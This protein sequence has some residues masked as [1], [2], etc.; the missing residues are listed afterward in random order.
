MA[1]IRRFG[2]TCMAMSVGRLALLLAFLL[3]LLL[4][5]AA[6]FVP[7]VQ[8][9]SGPSLNVVD[10]STVNYPT[11][12]VTFEALDSDGVPI[13][14]LDRSDFAVS[15]NGQPR[16]VISGYSMTGSSQALDVMLVLDTSVT[17]KNDG[18]LGQV[19]AAAEAF[20]D[21]M[22][23]VDQVGLIQF[24]TQLT[25][26]SPFSGDKAMLKRKI[27]G[28]T[29]QGNTRIYDALVLALN[30]TAPETGSK[31]V[32]LMTDGQDTES[33]AS[34]DQVLG[35]IHYTGIRVYTIG[36]GSDVDQGVLRE[37][38][39]ASGGHFY[40]APTAADIGNAF[41]LMSSQLR[42]RYQVIYSSPATAAKGSTMTLSLTAKTPQGLATG[43]TS[44]VVPAVA[45]MNQPSQPAPAGSSQMSQPQVA[46]KATAA[47]GKNSDYAAGGL[48]ALG[49]LLAAGGLAFKQAQKAHHTRL[50]YFI[51]GARGG[52]AAVAVDSGEGGGSAITGALLLPVVPLARLL[53]RMIARMLPPTQVRRTSHQ[54]L[55]AGNPFGWRVSHYV[56]ARILCGLGLAV[57]TSLFALRLGSPLLGV[58]IIVAFGF[59]GYRMP[60]MLLKRRIKSRQTSILKSLPDAL[61]LLTICVEAGLGL[62]GA[63][64]E[65]VNRWDNELSKEFAVVLAEQKMGRSRR[66][67]LRELAERTGVEEVKIFTSAMVQ[68]DELGM[69]IARPLA[70]QAE[71]LRT[72]RRQRAEK[73]A[74]EAGIKIIVAMGLLIMPALLT[75]IVAPAIVQ[76]GHLF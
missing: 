18:K 14:G 31:A 56:A 34:L 74:H 59:L 15:E 72:K 23:P 58:V 52:G 21:Q 43:Q 6:G 62:D 63:M 42:S 7:P 70:L 8:A 30:Q 3:A 36:I 25:Q 4:V 46:Q 2:T 53:A 73:Q 45:Q 1:S 20:V 51:G 75:I 19:Q 26:A 44:Y 24:D 60:M 39:Q 76:I 28:L 12:K 57:L 47:V 33:A 16:T 49:I 40:T 67:S 55:L 22:R 71:Q 69:G 66:E 5:L 13:A 35:L 11:I 54:L 38:A 68:A 32:V 64:L 48:A 10:V 61:D 29:A 17:M 37:I 41:R 9:A 65:V 27:T 50:A